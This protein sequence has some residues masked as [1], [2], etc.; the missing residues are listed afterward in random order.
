MCMYSII[1]AKKF[2]LKGGILYIHVYTLARGCTNFK[3]Y[4][5]YTY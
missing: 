4:L 2:K 5:I 3:L 1:V